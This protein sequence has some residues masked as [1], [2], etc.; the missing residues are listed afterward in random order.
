MT[1]RS[2]QDRLMEAAEELF[3]RR[4]FKDTSVREIA[5]AAGC[6]VAA[7][8]Y[9]FGGKE[10]LYVAV[11]GRWLEQMREARIDAIRRVMSGDGQR[12]LETLLE[13][14]ARTF[15]EP[16]AAEERL[17]QRQGCSRFVELMVREMVDPHLPTDMF[18]REMVSP[19]M[20]VLSEAVETLCP[21]LEP[22]VV[23]HVILSVV[24]QLVHAIAV[25]QMFGR[26]DDCDVPR[27][28]LEQ[29]VQHIVRFSAAGIRGYAN[30]ERK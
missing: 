18:V 20:V 11:W 25:R 30:G 6:N 9:Y 3:C 23:P 22:S 8:N 27:L 12:S 28:D 2:V 13:S 29:M 10:K 7:I 19:V 4:G 17:H 26:C 24:G 21:W 5:A 1:E 14:Y 15:V 16:L